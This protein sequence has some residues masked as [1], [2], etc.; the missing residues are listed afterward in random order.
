MGGGLAVGLFFRKKKTA[1]GRRVRRG[2]TEMGKEDSL[3]PEGSLWAE[4]S[5]QRGA[6]FAGGLAVGRTLR[7]KRR[8]FWRRARGGPSLPAKQ[9]PLWPEGSLG[10]EP[11]GTCCASVAAG[12][13][14]ARVLPPNGRLLQRHRKLLFEGRSTV[15]P[16]STVGCT[17]ILLASI[18]TLTRHSITVSRG[19][20]AQLHVRLSLA[21]QFLSVCLK[22]RTDL[23]IP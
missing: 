5:G 1:Y 21:R 14:C 15:V 3:W 20:R 9:A 7:P 19:N 23:P 4:P 6:S 18:L 17:C 12:L 11:S 2:G 10:A 13:A 16:L 22:D 8:L